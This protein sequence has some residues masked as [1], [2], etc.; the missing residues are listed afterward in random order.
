[1]SDRAATFGDYDQQAALAAIVGRVEVQ[2]C[3][4]EY[5]EGITQITHP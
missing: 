5:L 4:V 3:L 2:E 1:L